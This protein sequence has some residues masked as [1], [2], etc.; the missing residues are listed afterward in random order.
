MIS[1]TEH[2]LRDQIH[3]ILHPHH[4][5][6]FR[7]FRT[8]QIKEL[9]DLILEVW[10]VDLW[11]RLRVDRIFGEMATEN[12]RVIRA[13]IHKKHMQCLMFVDLA[14]EQAFQKTWTLSGG[15]T[16]VHWALGWQAILELDDSPQVVS[17]PHA[18]RCCSILEP[19]TLTDKA[20]RSEV[21]SFNELDSKEQEAAFQAAGQPLFT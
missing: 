11:G 8:F 17:T 15:E 20:G 12:S 1:E 9:Q 6:D 13:Q 4:D 2:L 3:D 7:T 19:E 18:C 5:K 14:S 16:Q 10:R 21:Y